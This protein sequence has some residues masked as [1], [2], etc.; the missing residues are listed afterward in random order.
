MQPDEKLLIT[1]PIE[2]ASFIRSKVNAGP[3]SSNSEI[4]REALRGWMEHEQRLEMLDAAIVRG[5]AY[6]ESGH[7]QGIDEV[8][9][10][11]HQ[12]FATN[13]EQSA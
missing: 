5:V 1:L 12:R 9:A 3:Y 11:L 8:R 10:E 2:M 7:V 4:I 13:F 6:A